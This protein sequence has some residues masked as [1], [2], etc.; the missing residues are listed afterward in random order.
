MKITAYS[1]ILV[2]T[3][4]GFLYRVNCSNY[5]DAKDLS[6]IRNLLCLLHDLDQPDDPPSF[7]MFHIDVSLSPLSASATLST[8]GTTIP[9]PSPASDLM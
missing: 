8:A 2:I 9:S 5:K 3:I 6:Q 4:L 1:M 7:N